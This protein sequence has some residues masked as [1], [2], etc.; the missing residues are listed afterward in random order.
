MKGIAIQ[1]AYSDESCKEFC[2]ELNRPETAI[3]VECKLF[4]MDSEK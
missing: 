4:G 3:G 2:Y 1:E